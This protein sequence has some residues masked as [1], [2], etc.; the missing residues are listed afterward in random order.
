LYT[1]AETVFIDLNISI[2]ISTFGYKG[3]KKLI[4]WTTS[5]YINHFIFLRIK[6]HNINMIKKIVCERCLTY[7]RATTKKFE[8]VTRRKNASGEWSVYVV[9]TKW[10][11]A[12][13][14]CTLVVTC[15]YVFLL[16]FYMVYTSYKFRGFNIYSVVQLLL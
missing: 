1:F 16:N 9:T 2:D 14:S 15:C 11:F 4:N 8:P 5:K 3:F 6:V 12:K 10:T 7:R 13:W